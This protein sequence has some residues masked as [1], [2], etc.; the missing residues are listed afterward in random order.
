VLFPGLLLVLV[1]FLLPC[2]PAQAGDSVYSQQITRQ[3]SEYELRLQ[4]HSRGLSALNELADSVTSIRN[5][6]KT[7]ADNLEPRVSILQANLQSLG[8]PGPDDS[9]AVKS[10]RR[11]INQKIND[12][13]RQLGS[14]KALL[15]RSDG[16]L[17]SINNRTRE[18]LA[19]QLLAQGP[20]IL[21]LLKN[22]WDQSPVWVDDT[23]IFLG[24]H[25][26]ID[27]LTPV[28][29]LLMSV[30]LLISIAAGLML[31]WWLNKRIELHSWRET[32][33][34]SNFLRAL[35]AAFATY[36]P[37]LLPSAAFATII[38]H[39]TSGIR[40]V[41]FITTVGLGLP[42]YYG[43]LIPIHLLFNPPGRGFLHPPEEL[44]ASLARRLRILA[45][46][47]FIGYLVFASLL[48]QSLPEPAILIFRAGFA[49][50]L[51]LNLIWAI[52][53]ILRLPLFARRTGLNFLVYLLLSSALLSEWAGYR[54]LSVT[55]IRDVLGSLAALGITV[56]LL[57][58]FRDIYDSL[59]SGDNHWSRLVHHFLGVKDGGKIPGLNSLRFLSAA[60][61]WIGL[62]YALLLVWDISD[63]ITLQI[64][65]LLTQGFTVGSLTIV[66]AKIGLALITIVLTLLLGGWVRNR[67]ETRW[68][69]MTLMDRGAREAVVTITGYVFMALAFIAGLSVA[70]F[71]FQNLAIIAGALSVGIGF[72]LQNIVNN[73]VSGLIILFER[74]IKTGDWIVVG[75][76]EGYV[77]RIR[78]RSTQIQ[79]FDRADVIVPNSELI[80]NQVT[81]WMLDNESGRLRLPV[82]VAYG[83][84]TDKVREILE[85]VA[86]DHPDIISNGLMPKPRILFREF[87]DSSLNFEL[88]A[89]IH[90]I[91]ERLRVVSDL[92]FAVDK[93]FREAGI[94]I[95]FPQRDVHLRD[96]PT[97]LQAKQ[98]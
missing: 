66:P 22:N 65:T 60:F 63:T 56:L 26:G 98:E 84:D 37:W 8:K 83:S 19:S 68:L 20:D 40:P 7:C 75:G 13:E 12:I 96:I 90:N 67:L 91:D 89:F 95:P 69:K 18:L 87:G 47:A 3:L 35:L 82:G 33:F 51:V 57:R 42:V 5:S 24:K 62:G 43:F 16:L 29:W 34:A 49:A 81:N 79:T 17:N 4:E 31:R 78:I 32:E 28:Q 45:V 1:A 59:E 77:K 94:E 72:G 14:C 54:N 74:P 48:E 70:G 41:P 30:A 55:L 46:L 92:N 44:A 71:E 39:I 88:L 64:S 27:L 80:S 38:Y 23:L 52:T 73:F 86:L 53:L 9:A 11:A 25:S 97:S 76:T 58:L 61:I 85:R 36:S 15:L 10:Q 21:E 50:A 2:H 93:A 6:A